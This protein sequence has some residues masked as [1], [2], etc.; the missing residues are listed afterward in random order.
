[1]ALTNSNPRLAIVYSSVTGNTE[2]LAEMVQEAAQNQGITI[3]LYP[4]DEFP[5]SQLQWLDVVMIGTYTW[6]SGEIP[7][8]MHSLYQA[9]EKLGRKELRTAVFGTGDS[10]FAEF[11]GAVDRFRDMLYTQTKL[12]AT[13]KVELMPQPSDEARCEKLIELM[14][15]Q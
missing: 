8:E 11:C 15:S 14:H 2:Q 1:M 9:I 13:L 5:L 10:F 3:E 4:V 7:E 6:G 12:V